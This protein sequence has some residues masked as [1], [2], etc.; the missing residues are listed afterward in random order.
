MFFETGLHPPNAKRI[1]YFLDGEFVGKPSHVVVSASYELAR[2][3]QKYGIA[4]SV[5]KAVTEF[6]A[7]MFGP[8]DV[9]DE[10]Q[11]GESSRSQGRPEAT[12]ATQQERQRDHAA[13]SAILEQ[14][15]GPSQASRA[16]PDSSRGI[17]NLPNDITPANE[18]HG[19]E[20]SPSQASREATAALQEQRERDQAE[21]TVM[22]VRADRLSQPSTGSSDS[23]SRVSALP[24]VVLPEID[25]TWHRITPETKQQTV[26]SMEQKMAAFEI[27]RE[28]RLAS[29]GNV[30]QLEAFMEYARYR[31]LNDAKEV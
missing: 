30:D 9:A 24:V 15:D 31:L 17:P 28:R 19:R 29:G 18:P 1:Q 20:S 3:S 22:L 27:V 16:L 14:D 13:E 21:E 23:G 12:G 25:E 2:L 26:K 4:D 7:N 5:R 10:S 11:D 6:R 8:K